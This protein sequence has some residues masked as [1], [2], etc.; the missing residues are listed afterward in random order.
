MEQLAFTAFLNRLF[1][2]AVLALLQALHIH[3]KHPATPISNSFAMELAGGAAAHDIFRCRALA[4]F[5]GAS[6]R[7]AAHDGRDPRIYH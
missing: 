2:P 5:G 3:P 7:V 4:A 1:G 6:R